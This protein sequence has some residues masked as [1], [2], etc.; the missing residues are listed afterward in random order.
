MD[1]YMIGWHSDDAM[2]CH[3]TDSRDVGGDIF[4]VA[5]YGEEEHDPAYDESLA[6]LRRFVAEANLG[7]ARSEELSN[8]GSAGHAITLSAEAFRVVCG[9]VQPTD[10]VDPESV[11]ASM[12]TWQEIRET[13][14]ASSYYDPDEEEASA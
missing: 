8:D 5:L 2:H 4:D 12:K 13:F 11:A 7:V 6:A 10:E 9:L 3:V 14:P 1:R